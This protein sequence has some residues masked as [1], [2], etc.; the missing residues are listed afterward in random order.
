MG[1]DEPRQQQLAPQVNIALQRMQKGFTL[2]PW[3]QRDNFSVLQEQQ[4][5]IEIA[6]VGGHLIRGLRHAG[7]IKNAPRTAVW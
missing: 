4:A 6:G 2:L 1:I 3:Q 5:I 7:D